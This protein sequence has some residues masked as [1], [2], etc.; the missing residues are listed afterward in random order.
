MECYIVTGLSG[1]G[2][3][4]ALKAFEDL[5]FYC[6]DNIPLILIPDAINTLINKTDISKIAIGVDI[7]ERFFLD[8]F[9]VFFNETKKRYPFIKIIYLFADKKV[10][11]KRFKE[12]RRIHPLKN[13]SF[14]DAIEKEEK[15]LES[16]KNK[17]EILI[18]T[19]TFTVHELKKYIYD[20]F[21][22][23]DFK[24]F[25]VNIVSFGFKNGILIEGDLIFDVRFIPNPFF[26]ENLKL[27]TGLD[28]EVVDFIFSF[29]ETVI[30]Y[31]KVKSLMEFLIPLYKK[32][33]K[34]ILIIGFGCTGGQHR[35]VVLANKI[36]HDLKDIFPMTI[37]HRDL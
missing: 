4:T 26:I 35:S 27:K 31:N 20:N 12:T 16:L 2:K 36:Y 8:K 24:I 23:D 34:N 28:K 37:R 1:S 25:H 11:I 19:S 10:I 15:I 17:A 7:R 14:I 22:T 18:D 29:K 33:G 32:E 6:I 9:E 21:S 13:Y 3:T 5:G 30:F